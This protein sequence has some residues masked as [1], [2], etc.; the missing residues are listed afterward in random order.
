ML[1]LHWFGTATVGLA[2]GFCL[3]SPLIQHVQ[4]CT[5]VWISFNSQNHFQPVHTYMY[6]HVCRVEYVSSLGHATKAQ[7]GELCNKRDMWAQIKTT[8]K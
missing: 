3:Q 7:F 1:K 4:T 2:A 5:H 6:V 8:H